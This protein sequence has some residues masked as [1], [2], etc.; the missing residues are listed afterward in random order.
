MNTLK[1]N[2]TTNKKEVVGKIV[3]DEN[4]KG[5]LVKDNNGQKLLPGK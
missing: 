1:K 2:T 4:A 5:K 3:T